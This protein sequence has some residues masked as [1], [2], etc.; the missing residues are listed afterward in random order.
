MPQVVRSDLLNL[1][2]LHGTG[3]AGHGRQICSVVTE[4]EVFEVA[5][6]ALYRELVEDE[7]RYW[8]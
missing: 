7:L 5:A 8:Y 3:V 6:L 2:T 4:D 1:G